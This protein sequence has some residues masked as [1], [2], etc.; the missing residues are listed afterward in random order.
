MYK[1]TNEE[2][3]FISILSENFLDSI[4]QNK[5]SVIIKKQIVENLFALEN[6]QSKDSGFREKIEKEIEKYDEVFHTYLNEKEEFLKSL[7]SKLESLFEIIKENDREA[8]DKANY[9]VTDKP[10]AEIRE[11]SSNNNG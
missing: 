1:L 10:L 6:L 2:I 11:E 4:E 7:F 8:F 3:C 9:F 5:K